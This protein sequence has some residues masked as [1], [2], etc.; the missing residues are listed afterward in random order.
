MPTEIWTNAKHDCLYERVV[1]QFGPYDEW[2]D[3]TLPGRGLNEAFRQFCADFARITGAN[4]A[5][6]V[7]MQLR[8]AMPETAEGSTWDQARARTAI[9]NKAA[10]L[11]A[12]FIRSAHLPTLMVSRR[13]ANPT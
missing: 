1:E 5:D 12:G 3:T 6:A 13:D 8:Y 2:T 4:S 10:A 7:H 9:L 11:R